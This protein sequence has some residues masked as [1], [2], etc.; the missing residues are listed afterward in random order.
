M[1]SKDRTAVGAD[2]TK[3]NEKNFIKKEK[4]L[5]YLIQFVGLDHRSSSKIHGACYVRLLQSILC[6]PR[7]PWTCKNVQE[8]TLFLVLRYL[9]E[10]FL[11]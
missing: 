1:P 10:S 3:K 6:I 11:I 8:I 4:R 9:I 5:P 7:V 2:L